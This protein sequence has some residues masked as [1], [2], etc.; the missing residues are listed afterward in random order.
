MSRTVAVIGASPERRKFGNKSVRAHLAA[1]FTVFPITPNADEVEGLR[2]YKSVV[3]VPVEKL[4]RV[5]I[6]LPPAIGLKVL[7]EIA[8]KAPGE[9]WFNP[10]AD[11]PEVLTEA[12]RLGLN[13]IAACSIVDLGLS[14]SA[15]GDT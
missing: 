13:V 11:A 4:D 2:A 15:F 10:G 12:R 1:G 9:V 7:P 8:M 3:D 6:Y 14:P 5:T